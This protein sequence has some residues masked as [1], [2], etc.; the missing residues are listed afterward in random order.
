MEYVIVIV[1][2]YL[3]GSISPA[4][5]IGKLVGDIDIRDVNSMN[6]G[7][8]NVTITFGLKYGAPVAILDILK[9]LVPILALRYFYPDN[10]LMW[11]TGGISAVIGHIFPFYMGFRGGKGTSTFIG[12]LL[13]TNPVL[14]LILGIGL[15]IVTIVTDYIAIGTLF[16]ILLAP[17]MLYVF[18]YHIGA[19][20]WVVAY[21]I[22]SFYKHFGNFVRIYHKQELGL[23]KAF[24]K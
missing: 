18:D 17:L 1:L 13:A 8:S 12:V 9:S 20:I 19:V 2:F 22:L 4:L 15:I 5:I 21:S 24:K 3:I 7:A 23:R 16:L 10:D 11:F 6:A 14:G